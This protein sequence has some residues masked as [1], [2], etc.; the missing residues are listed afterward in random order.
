DDRVLLEVVPLARNVGGDLHAVREANTAD[1]AERRVGLL[2]RRGVDADAD[3]ALLRAAL[4]RRGGRLES[5]RF[6]AM[7]DEL[8][9]GG[10]LYSSRS[11]ASSARSSRGFCF[12]VPAGSGHTCAAGYGGAH[13]TQ[14]GPSV[15]RRSASES[16]I[17]TRFAAR[18]A[19]ENGTRRREGG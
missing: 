5:G 12:E 8:I 7:V 17:F 4:E 16:G 18:S 2:R 15:K 9:D 3:A 6:P 13:S 11:Y 1:L 19:P 14:V 10:H